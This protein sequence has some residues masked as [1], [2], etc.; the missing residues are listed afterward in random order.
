MN[1]ILNLQKVQTNEQNLS[2][3]IELNWSILCSE[4]CKIGF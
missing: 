1:E 2:S 3:T 4:R